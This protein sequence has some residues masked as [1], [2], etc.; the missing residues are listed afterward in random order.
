MAAADGDLGH[1]RGAPPA[2]LPDREPFPRRRPERA[3]RRPPPGLPWLG[4]GRPA[5]LWRGD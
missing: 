3:P 2:G 5:G 4:P 1:R